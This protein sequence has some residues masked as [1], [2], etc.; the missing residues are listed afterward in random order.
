MITLKEIAFV[1]I[2]PVLWICGTHHVPYADDVP[3]GMVLIP[4]GEFE[5]GSNDT[6]ADNDERPVRRVY[7][8]AFYID[9]TEVTNLQFQEFLIENPH[10]QKGR[11][12][13][14]FAD[15]NYLRLWNGNNYP[16]GKEN[17]PVRYVSWYAAMAYAEWADKR[18]PTERDANFGNNVEY[19][20]PVGKYVAN[21]YSLYD[22]AGNVWEWCLDEYDSEFYFTFPRNGVAHNPL[23]DVNSIDWILDNYISLK[24]FRVLRGGSWHASAQNV[25]VSDRYGSTPANTLLSSGFRCVRSETHD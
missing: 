7:V 12:N 4:A 5:M 2:A 22:M 25:R 20:T 11:V 21:G 13:K 14:Q 6:E 15:G 18:L 24:S 3:D 9:E 10:W 1:L 23:S 16:N 19:T 8:D 17:N